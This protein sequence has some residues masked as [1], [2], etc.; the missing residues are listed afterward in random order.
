M[1]LRNKIKII[2]SLFI[3]LILSPSI[4]AAD[5]TMVVDYLNIDVNITKDNQ[6]QIKETYSNNFLKQSHG[7]FREVATDYSK[8]GFYTLIKDEYCSTIMNTDKGQFSTIYKIGN[9]DQLVIGNQDYTFGYTLDVG[10]N[11]N[12]EK[13]G[14]DFIYYTLIQSS[15]YPIKKADFKITFPKEINQSNIEFAS[16]KFGDKGFEGTFTLQDDKKTII[17]SIENL[18]TMQNVS[19]YVDLPADYFVGQRDFLDSLNKKFVAMLIVLVLAF[20]LAYILFNRY[21]RDDD[22]VEVQSFD[23]PNGFNPMQLAHFIN[24]D[25]S[26]KD[27][28]SM[29]FYWADRGY[30]RIIEDEPDKKGKSEYTIKKLKEL[31]KDL[32]KSETKMFEAYFHNVEID[33]EITLED[34]D[35]KF[36][37]RRQKATERVSE[38]FVEKNETELIEP[39]SKSAKNKIVA[40]AA[41]IFF[42]FSI[43]LLPESSISS[44]L[45]ISGVY[46]LINI[47]IFIIISIFFSRTINLAATKRISNKIGDV[48]ISITIIVGLFIKEVFFLLVFSGLNNIPTSFVFKFAIFS[49]ISFL[50]LAILS[51]LTEKRSEYATNTFGK[52]LGYKSFIEYVEIDK[53]KMMIDEDPMLFYHTLSFAIVLGLEKKWYKKFETIEIPQN[54]Y[55]G[56]Y[57]MGNMGY[58]SMFRGI[59]NFNH[60][61]IDHTVASSVGSAGGRGIGGGGFS[62]SAGGGFGGGGT[63]GTW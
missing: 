41:V 52:I 44:K 53:L 42:A 60:T 2:L 21:G 5:T 17:G 38:Y 47:S 58:R 56:F 24:R 13:T 15:T 8:S 57:M 55:F 45:A 27:T 37:K 31:P 4:F 14:L 43:I 19:V 29:L 32:D 9:P 48:I 49:T 12:T 40:I 11:Y 20:I 3:F 34:L 35:Q 10:K 30:L 46:L 36:L 25:V 39:K 61:V 1:N 16:G 50:V 26:I 54:N 33:E 62:A 18:D 23:V 7:F 22:I 63:N 51:A 28:T 59:D 6:Y